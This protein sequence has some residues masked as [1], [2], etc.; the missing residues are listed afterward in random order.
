MSWGRL[1]CKG[2][3]GKRGPPGEKGHS[4]AGMG[5]NSIQMHS[6]RFVQH[7]TVNVR[8]PIII[9]EQPTYVFQTL[10]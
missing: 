9:V 4:I 2:P 10:R 3:E 1:G 7:R 5:L 6:N 8:R